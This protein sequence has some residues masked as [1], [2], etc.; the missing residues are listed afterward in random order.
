MSQESPVQ[1]QPNA[2]KPAGGR[3]ASALSRGRV[4]LLNGPV[5]PALLSF[6]LP[7]AL[8][9]LV[10]MIYSLIDTY[11]VSH[12]GKSAIA[13][14]G[15][16]EQL[17][18]FVFNFGSGFAIGTGV[19]LARRM[20]EGNRDAA[21]HTATQAVTSMIFFSILLATVLYFAL[22][23]ILNMLMKDSE[24]RE[25]AH[26]YLSALLF[27]VPGNFITFLVSSVVRSSG[28]SVLPMTVLVITTII[29]AILAPMLIFG[30]GPI[31][32]LGMTGA[33]MATAIAQLTGAGISLWVFMSGK[34]GVKFVREKFGFDFPLLGK[35]IKQSVPAALQM[36]SVSI[37]RLSLFSIASTFGTSVVAAY[38]L[39]LKIDLFV[40]MT[41]FA[42]GIAVEVAT[43]QNL[44]ARKP[45]R[46]WLFH[47]AAI[48][49][50]IGVVILLG[51]NAFFFGKYYAGIFTSDEAV[52]SEA[53]QYLHIAVFGYLFFAIGL[54]T[55]RVIS[56]SGA[57]IRS[58]TIVAGS[59]LLLQL[60]SSY[61]LAKYTPLHQTGIWIGV[62]VGYILF[63]AIALINLYSKKWMTTKV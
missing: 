61:L 55:T 49:Q 15:F 42:T 53:V 12:L 21:N 7:L 57:A 38:T 47:K 54:V 32:A 62:V 60:P 23:Y 43:G 30:F 4:D 34:S 1:E 14:I 56:G 37:T 18:F 48:R 27:G 22:P 35:I 24:V 31:P 44:G 33:G 58:M 51:I 19:I 10:N 16:S 63:T 8:S 6:S 50:L 2:G 46:I 20:G 25:F 9:F 26:L 40:F 17:G 13:A 52:I 59:L 3:P 36:F 29:N 11:F 5:A 39:G 45:E 41:V 28:N